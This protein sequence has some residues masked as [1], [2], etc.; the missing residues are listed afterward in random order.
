[1]KKYSWFTYKQKDEHGRYVG[2]VIY[3]KGGIAPF[4]K[5]YEHYKPNMKGGHTHNHVSNA[6][7]RK[8]K[9][10]VIGDKIFFC[11]IDDPIITRE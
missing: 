4:R 2:N 5:C 3:G 7:Y 1:M 11:T 10:H 9:N 8:Y 6:L